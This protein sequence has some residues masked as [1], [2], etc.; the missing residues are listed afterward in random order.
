MK[1]WFQAFAFSNEL[2]PLLRRGVVRS[3]CFMAR[4]VLIALDI[5]TLQR[6]QRTAATVGLYKFNAVDPWLESAQL[7]SAGFNP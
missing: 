3:P 2:V 6:C 5:F 4:F 1:D 7:E